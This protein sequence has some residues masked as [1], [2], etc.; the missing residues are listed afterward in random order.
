MI[1]HQVRSIDVSRI[2]AWEYIPG[3]GIQYLGDPLIRKGV[4]DS[5]A[6]HFG[7]DIPAPNDG[8]DP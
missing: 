7:L 3:Q 8:A 4:R 1:I 5:L 2:L 6:V